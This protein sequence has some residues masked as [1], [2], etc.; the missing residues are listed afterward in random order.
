MLRGLRALVEQAREGEARVQNA[1]GGAVQPGGN[2]K[3][4]AVLEE[5]FE[6]CDSA[7]RGIGVIPHSGLAIRERL[8]DLDASHRFEVR[9][10]QPVEPPGCRCGEVLRGV[11]EPEAC[12]LFGCTCTPENPRGACMVSN[13][14]SCAARYRY[15]GEA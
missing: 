2:A 13:E 7:W 4:R 3:A 8:H 1:Y 15:G 5:V 9:L 10:P 6:P 14:G 11:L 12:P